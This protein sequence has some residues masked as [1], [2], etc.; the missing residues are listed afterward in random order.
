MGL[1]LRKRNGTEKEHIIIIVIII[2]IIIMEWNYG[3]SESTADTFKAPIHCQALPYETGVRN[4]HM[5]REHTHFDFTVEQRLVFDANCAC[6]VENSA[7]LDSS[8]TR[9]TV[10]W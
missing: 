7:L 2:I 8:Q 10:R 6:Y 9:R 3:Y 4:V 1:L 5:L